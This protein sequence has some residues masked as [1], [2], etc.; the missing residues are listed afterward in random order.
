MFS[1]FQC[2]DQILEKRLNNEKHFESDVHEFKHNG[3]HFLVNCKGIYLSF[4]QINYYVW[5]LKLLLNVG[6]KHKNL[7]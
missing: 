6:K 7:N 2:Y 5:M 4:G 1:S 3:V